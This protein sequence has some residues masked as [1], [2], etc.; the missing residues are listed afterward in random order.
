MLS[1]LDADTEGVQAAW[2]RKKIVVHIRVAAPDTQATCTCSKTAVPL[3][4]WTSPEHPHGSQRTQQGQDRQGLMKQGIASQT[5]Q[6]WQVLVR[7]KAA[8]LGLVM[9]AV[10]DSSQDARDWTSQPLRT[11]RWGRGAQPH[12]CMGV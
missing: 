9:H 8:G 12:C 10:T 3:R 2:W 1:L 5:Q 6:A 11:H 4:C 7:L